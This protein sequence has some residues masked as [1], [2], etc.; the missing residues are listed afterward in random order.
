[1]FVSLASRDQL[2]LLFT[3]FLADSSLP[4]ELLD[5]MTRM[6]VEFSKMMVTELSLVYYISFDT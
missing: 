1:M 6:V 5:S 4:Q 2:G 3:S